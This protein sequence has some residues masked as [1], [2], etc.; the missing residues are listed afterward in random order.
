MRTRAERG[1]ATVEFAIAGLLTL[2]L[3]FATME[4]SRLLYTWNALTDATRR[5]ARLAA[6]C[7]PAVG[8][9]VAVKR[10]TRWLRPNGDDTGIGFPGLVETNVK[11]RYFDINGVEIA[12]AVPTA[13]RQRVQF[14]QVAI[15]GY[16][17]PLFIPG[18]DLRIPMPAFQTTLP[19]ESLGL[20]PSN[21]GS[22]DCTTPR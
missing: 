4:F 19:S 13:A 3:L 17:L 9:Q 18:F 22:T 8:Q 16:E 5:G 11:V 12:D 10:V 2:T 6:V 7:S 14:V 15:E 1:L 21:A 20:V